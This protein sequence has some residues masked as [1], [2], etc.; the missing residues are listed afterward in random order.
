MLTSAVSLAL[1]LVAFLL[2]LVSVRGLVDDGQG[3]RGNPDETPLLRG[4]LNHLANY[5]RDKSADGP[6]PMPNGAGRTVMLMPGIVYIPVFGV[7][8]WLSCARVHCTC[9]LCAGI[10]FVKKINRA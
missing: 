9:K 1:P 2:D 4:V 7:A 6:R 8:M 10:S 3:N 5:Q